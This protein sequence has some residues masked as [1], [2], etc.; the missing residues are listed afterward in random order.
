MKLGIYSYYPFPSLSL[1]LVRMKEEEVSVLE[2]EFFNYVDEG[3]GRE[4]EKI[5]A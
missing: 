2:D 3:T 1:S 5:A 4:T